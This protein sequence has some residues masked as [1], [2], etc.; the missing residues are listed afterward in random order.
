MQHREV[1]NESFGGR[2]GLEDSAARYV[3]HAPELETC[4]HHS[5]RNTMPINSDLSTTLRDDHEH[6]AGHHAGDHEHEKHLPS[7]QRLDGREDL[8][9]N[10]QPAALMVDI[11]DGTDWVNI[12]QDPN[13]S[14]DFVGSGTG[15]TVVHRQ[16]RSPPP[17]SPVHSFASKKNARTGSR[18]SGGFMPA[19]TSP[20]VPQVAGAGKPSEQGVI[21][22]EV[23]YR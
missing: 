10:L 23:A 9:V 20:V 8:F 5:L 16:H 11:D 4:R 21:G 22:H 3:H 19:M 12:N 6:H 14:T 1:G 2:D 18:V 15:S 13:C 17:H 7:P